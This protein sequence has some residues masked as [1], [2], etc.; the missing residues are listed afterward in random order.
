MLF[1]DP[2]ALSL[3]RKKK[4]LQHFRVFISFFKRLLSK[5]KNVLR[6]ETLNAEFQPVRNACKE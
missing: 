2:M 5:N 1:G 3:S 4:G 6:V